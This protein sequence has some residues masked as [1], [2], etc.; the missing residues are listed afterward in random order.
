VRQLFDVQAYPDL[1]ESE[2]GAPEPPYDAAGMD[3][4]FLTDV[5]VVER[6][7]RSAP[8]SSP[9]AGVQGK[10]TDAASADAPLTTSAMAAGIVTARRRGSR[11]RRGTRVI[12]RRTTHFAW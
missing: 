12:P 7:Y 6:A 3:T 1:R 9:H 4:S 8:T 5:R 10:A 11:H 2:G